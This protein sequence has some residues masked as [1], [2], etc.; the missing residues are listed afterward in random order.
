MLEE[1]AAFAEELA[2]AAGRAV[3]E[4]YR[5]P[6]EVDNKARGGAFDPVTVADRAAETIMRQ[7]IANRFPGHGIAGEEFPDTDPDAEYLWVLDPIDGTKSFI[8]GFPAWGTLIGLMHRGEPVLGVMSQ[9]FTGELFVG[10]AGQ[11]QYR[12]PAGARGL[13]TRS[14][15]TL[16]EAMLTTTSPQL[17]EDEADL[18]RYRA[19][20]GRVR[21]ARYGG[22]CYGYCMLADGQIDLVAE[23][24]L[25]MHDIAPLVPIITGAGGIV[26]DWKGG[27]PAN[28]GRI[29]AAGDSVL[30][31]AALEILGA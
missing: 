25:K 30:H 21:L 10:F 24:G 9:P 16:A 3:L 8:L 31:G 7:M 11:A 5:R 17:I 22:D 27:P 23:T 4:H 20:E 13:K 28:G 19:L 15:T 14:C 6:L 2:A 29:V 18:E 1:F 12:G 26:T